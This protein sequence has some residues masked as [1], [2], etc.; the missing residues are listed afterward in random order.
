MSH[1]LLRGASQS[2][3]L[4]QRAPPL[5]LHQARL[6]RFKLPVGQNWIQRRSPDLIPGRVQVEPI[7]HEVLRFYEP[8]GSASGVNVSQS[9]IIGSP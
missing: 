4:G 7:R 8:S 6:T 5:R 9:V 2:S 1:R 3:T